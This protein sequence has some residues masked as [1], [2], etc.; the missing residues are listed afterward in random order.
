M[1]GVVGSA[2]K[3][4]TNEPTMQ[5]DLCRRCFSIGDVAC[6]FIEHFGRRGASL[7]TRWFANTPWKK[8]IMRNSDAGQSF[9]P[10]SVILAGQALNI[11]NCCD[12]T[13]Y[14]GR[15]LSFTD[16]YKMELEH[17]LASFR[18]KFHSMRKELCG[19]AFSLKHQ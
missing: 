19:K 14:L 11:L 5:P 8:H 15:L 17:R 12:A 16:T 4:R 13:M 9:V 6:P 1:Q 2:D 7:S 3:P 18:K 10:Q